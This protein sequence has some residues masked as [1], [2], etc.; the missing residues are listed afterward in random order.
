MTLAKKLMNFE[1]VLINMSAYT[2]PVQTI[3]TQ[4]GH[5]LLVSTFKNRI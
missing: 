1:I 2:G 3:F 5:F 4:C